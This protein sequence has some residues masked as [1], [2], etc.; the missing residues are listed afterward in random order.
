MSV[1]FKTVA[2]PF[3]PALILEDLSDRVRG[4]EYPTLA[5]AINI[6]FSIKNN[7]LTQPT[8]M[9]DTNL[10]FYLVFNI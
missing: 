1:G 8:T 6:M 4:E 10:S 9:I 3:V 7:K 5:P 2:S